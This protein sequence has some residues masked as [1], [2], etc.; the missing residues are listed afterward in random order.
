MKTL[1][2]D[3]L[4]ILNLADL[5]VILLAQPDAETAIDGMHKVA[6][7]ISERA[8]S[9]RDQIEDKQPIAG[10][11]LRRSEV[12]DAL[13][14]IAMMV[15]ALLDAQESMQ[16]PENKPSV[17]EVPRADG[18]M[19]SFAAIDLEKRVKALRDELFPT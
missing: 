10:A 6:Q 15:S 13:H 3:S 7:T 18:E 9:V 16:A 8:R 12:D 19:I 11:V 4:V 5:L 14:G 17:F 1:D 2:E